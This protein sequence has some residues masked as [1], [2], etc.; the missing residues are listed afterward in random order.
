MLSVF[1]LRKDLPP[2]VYDVR[3]AMADS[4]GRP[5]IRLAID[6]EDNQKRYRLGSVRI[7]PAM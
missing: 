5:R 3:I 4:S 2:G 6:G 1:H 7:L